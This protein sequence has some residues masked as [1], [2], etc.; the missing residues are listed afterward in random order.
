VNGSAVIE[1]DRDDNSGRVMVRT[2]KNWKHIALL[3]E[4]GIVDVCSKFQINKGKDDNWTNGIKAK[5]RK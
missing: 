5:L 1:L 4:K 3:D 2:I